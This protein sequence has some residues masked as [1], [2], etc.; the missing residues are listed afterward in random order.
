MYRRW[1]F[2]KSRKSIEALIADTL[3]RQVAVHIG[4]MS[5]GLAINIRFIH[6]VRSM[7][8]IQLYT[9]TSTHTQ[10]TNRHRERA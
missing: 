2:S 10:H 8:D 5:S 3:A 7:K 6:I 1:M 9:Q 4:I